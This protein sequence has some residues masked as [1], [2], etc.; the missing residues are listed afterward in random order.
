MGGSGPEKCCIGAF[1]RQKQG[2]Q[3]ALAP[4]PNRGLVI[5]ADEG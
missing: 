5:V 1:K 2:G 4:L 3:M